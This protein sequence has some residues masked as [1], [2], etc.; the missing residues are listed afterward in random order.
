MS[1]RGVFWSLFL[2]HDCQ[3]TF[4]MV[5]RPHVIFLKRIPLCF[6]NPSPS[7]NWAIKRTYFDP[8]FELET[9]QTQLFSLLITAT[10]LCENNQKSLKCFLWQIY[11]F[12]PDFLLICSSAMSRQ[13][14]EKVG[15]EE[16]FWNRFFHR[17]IL[18]LKEIGVMK[19]FN[20]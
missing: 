20:F 8:E 1:V 9:F 10:F 15:K 4:L 2:S 11:S 6:W 19:D 17:W 18:F 7:Q 12:L 14:E 16:T 5:C 13:E 3:I